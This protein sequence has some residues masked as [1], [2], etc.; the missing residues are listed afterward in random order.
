MLDH[1]YTSEMVST[2]ENFSI[3]CSVNQLLL[4]ELYTNHFCVDHAAIVD[5]EL[6]TRA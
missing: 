1:S 2:K 3:P 5:L 4:K 6:Q